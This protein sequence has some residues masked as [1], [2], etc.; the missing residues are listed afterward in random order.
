MF[1]VKHLHLRSRAAALAERAR[2][3][4]DED[5]VVAAVQHLE[6]EVVTHAAASSAAVQAARTHAAEVANDAKQAAL[7]AAEDVKQALQKEIEI[8]RVALQ[9]VSGK[10]D[11]VA[12][13]V[14]SM[15]SAKLLQQAVTSLA[16]AALIVFLI[17]A[18]GG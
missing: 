10:V 8:E 1:H 13:A 4:M 3:L 18:F 6:A 9:V 2:D 11:A 15:A 14:Q 5:R 12:A 16:L 17:R 7:D